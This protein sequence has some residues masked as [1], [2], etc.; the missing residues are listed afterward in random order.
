MDSFARLPAELL[1]AVLGAPAAH[2]R[3][4]CRRWLRALRLAFPDDDR[5]PKGAA[6]GSAELAAWY[7]ELDPGCRAWLCFRA[8]ADGRLETLR[9]ARAQEPPCAWGRATCFGAARGGHLAILQWARTR[10]PPCLKSIK[11]GCVA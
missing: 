7:C 5:T 3:L 6:A 1:A 8:A 2:L 11:S 4:V 9:W 10:S